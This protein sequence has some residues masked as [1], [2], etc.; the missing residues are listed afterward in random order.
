MG[1]MT[2]DEEAEQLLRAAAAE[3]TAPGERECLVCFVAR[4][5]DEFG[6]DNTL[7]FATRYRDLHAPRAHALERRLGDMGGYCDCEVLL[8]GYQLS[9]HLL[10]RDEY[11]ELRSP[12]RRPDCGRVRL[13]ST[14]PCGNWERQ[15]CGW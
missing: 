3:L 8:N 15:R 14:Q 13:G 9:R 4:M 12:E 7:R 10:E 11:D 1:E 2:I 6:C 5:L